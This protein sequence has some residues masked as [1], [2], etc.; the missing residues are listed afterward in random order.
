MLESFQ[1]LPRR[2]QSF[3]DRKPESV[4]L[5]FRDKTYAQLHFVVLLLFL[6]KLLF[7]V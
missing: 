2:R 6:N 1:F 7:I 3:E 4:V 5:L